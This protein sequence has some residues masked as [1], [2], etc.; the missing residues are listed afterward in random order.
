ME[1]LLYPVVLVRLLISS[2]PGVIFPNPNDF[3]FFGSSI[4]RAG[5]FNADGFDDI[6]ISCS[7]WFSLSA[8][9]YVVY[10][11]SSLPT[12]FDLNTLTSATGVRYFSPSAITF[13][14]AA[15][16]G[17]VDFNLDG[18]D[19]IVIGAQYANNNHGTTH[20]VFGSVSPPVEASVF[21]LGDGGI[22][23]NATLIVNKAF[24]KVVALAEN[25]GGV[26]TRGLLVTAVSDVSGADSLYY[27]HDLFATDSPSVD[28]TVLPTMS[29]TDTPSMAPTVEPTFSPSASPS[30]SPT[31]APS[32]SPSVVPS[33]P[34]SVV[35][36]NEP[37]TA[38]T[39]IPTMT[40]TTIPTVF[41]SFRP[42][43]PTYSP[44]AAPTPVPTVRT[45]ASIVVV[46]DFTVRS[47]NGATLNP[48][49]QEKFKQSITNASQITP[50]N[51]HL[52]SMTR[53]NRRLL[54]SPRLLATVSLFI[55]RVVAEIHFHLI[56][57]PGMN[58]SYITGSKSKGLTK[59]MKTH[60]FDRSIFYY[61]TINNATQ[62]LFNATVLDVMVTTSVV[63]VP[64]SA[65]EEEDPGL[66]DGQVAG[67]VIGI[68]MGVILLS[69]FLYLSV[70]KVR[71]GQSSDDP[72]VNYD[73]VSGAKEEEIAVDMAQVYEER[74][75][76]DFDR[77][78]N[79]VLTQ[80]L[81]EVKL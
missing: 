30:S 80:G 49:S 43:A 15:V 57:F 25:V 65:E 33:F 78:A 35:P 5:D 37:T 4:A 17:G 16:S 38:P 75:M 81:S 3:S 54:L 60:E 45:K 31:V 53:T 23:L 79:R 27:L 59:A 61:A 32:M 40:P 46:A 56:D 55:H 41:P 77:S 51:V 62:L 42:S 69:G 68:V 71:S 26:N 8:T 6:A 9:V 2:F 66:S 28:P 1:E 14:W 72:V 12:I 67:V 24:G 70:L 52:G 44:S 48:T 11:G 20:V 18:I 39:V 13:S 50:N 34:P 22:T 36:T 29:P 21:Q 64:N 63:P 7:G 19:D 76:D 47:V 74:N 10:G 73:K 58:E